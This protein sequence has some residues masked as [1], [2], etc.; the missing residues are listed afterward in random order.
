MFARYQ[1][2][3]KILIELRRY[4]KILADKFRIQLTTMEI[5]EIILTKQCKI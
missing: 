4:T 1:I 5:I 3:R 2:G